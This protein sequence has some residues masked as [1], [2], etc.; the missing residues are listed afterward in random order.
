MS[1]GIYG[2]YNTRETG[3]SRVTEGLAAALSKSGLDVTVYVHGDRREPPCEGVDLTH[4]GP[5][6]SSVRGYLDVQRR[7][8]AEMADHE[9]THA[10][11]GFYGSCTVDTVQW[12]SGEYERWRRCPRDFGGYRALA[13]DVLL[14]AASRVGAM[15]SETV[16]A[17]SPET[18]R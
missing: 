2:A 7:A 1:V 12:T 14:T 13:G 17:S 4:L 6:P 8:R 9:V 5:S 11:G 18:A 16:V 15:R 3:P 10:L